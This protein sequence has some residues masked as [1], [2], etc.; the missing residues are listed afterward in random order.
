MD[1]HG[2]PKDIYYMT[3][4]QS[5]NQGYNV[6]QRFTVN[7]KFEKFQLTCTFFFSV[8]SFEDGGK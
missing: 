8:G 7:T 5:A 1:R 2:L 4:L 3:L 6:R